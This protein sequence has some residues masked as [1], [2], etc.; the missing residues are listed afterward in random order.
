MELN[1]IEAFLAIANSGSFSNAA[2]LL[3]L[4]Q[5]AITRRI[6]LLERELDVILLDRIKG[7]VKLTEA[8]AALLPHARRVMAGLKDCKAAV[9]A[10]KESASGEVGIAL[11]GTLAST[12][13]TQKLRA[14]RT[15][16]PTILIKLRTARSREVNNLVLG[17]EVDLG[18]R[19][20]EAPDPHLVS[21]PAGSERLVVVCAADHPLSQMTSLTIR[22]LAGYPWV[23]YP[24]NT[25]GEPFTKVLGR[26]LQKVELEDQST[27][28]LIDSLTAQKRLIEAG[29][30]LGLLPISS[31]QEELHLE[32]LKRLPISALETTVPIT[33]IHRKKGFLS[34]AVESIKGELLMGGY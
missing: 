23:A 27:T 20:F 25:S 34:K 13:L 18:L 5:P 6:Q 22:D 32:T 21:H 16:F 29:F 2:A 9:H 7:G 12:S 11:V 3:H 19:Y 15:L 31:I 8:G 28:I 10:L 17:G 26:Q 1:S 33:L 24:S 30:G 14:F 4:S